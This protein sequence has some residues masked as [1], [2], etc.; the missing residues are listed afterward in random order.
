MD[1]LS[2]VKAELKELGFSLVNEEKMVGRVPKGGDLNGWFIEVEI[3]LTNFPFSSPNIF[4]KSVNNNENL[5]EVIPDHW[6][7]LDELV[8]SEDIEDS[9]FLVCCLH[10]WRANDVY[11]GEFIYSR[12]LNWLQSNCENNWEEGSEVQGWRMTPHISTSK[13]YLAYDFA[14]EVKAKAL[15]TIKVK[16]SIYTLKS[17]GKVSGKKEGTAYSL[18]EIDFAQSYSFYPNFNFTERLSRIRQEEYIDTEFITLRLPQSYK[19]TTFYQLLMKVRANFNLKS[20]TNGKKSFPFVVLYKG[21]LGKLEA[22]SFIANQN[23][24]EGKDKFKVKPLKVESIPDRPISVDLKVGLYGVGSLG[25]Q[26]ARILTDKQT[27]EIILHDNQRFSSDN[28]GHHELFGVSLGENKAIALRNQLSWI[29]I[30]TR[31]SAVASS[32]ELSEE[33]DLLVVTV[34]SSQEYDRIAFNELINYEKPIIWAWTSPYNVLQ[35]I[36]ITTPKTGCLNCYY[37]LS[38]EDMKLVQFNEFKDAELSGLPSY[39][40]DFCGEPHTES[41]WE[42]NVFLATQIVS[43]INYFSKHNEFN[44][45][46]F[47][48]A[49]GLNDIIATP[50]MGNIPKH[51]LCNCNRRIQ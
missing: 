17:G 37:Q 38:K 49:W 39:N 10:N 20:V 12:I 25:S 36:V 46:Y 51:N 41:Q 45:N 6:K 16:Q 31:V 3:T 29:S 14:K 50:T 47:A 35:E 19:F 40:Y 43:A 4:L 44:F 13:I 26:V 34:G 33:S 8:Y 21:F 42:K 23:F 2:Q 32:A 1:N 27:K 28:L 11:N 5:Y 48:F 9:L 15:G 7:H 30:D 22:V 24:I 18:E